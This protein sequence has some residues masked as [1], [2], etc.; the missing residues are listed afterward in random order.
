MMMS[1]SVWGIEADWQQSM[2]AL[3]AV[4]KRS[5]LDG[6]PWDATCS[7]R[8]YVIEWGKD[9]PARLLAL[10]RAGHRVVFTKEGNDSSPFVARHPLSL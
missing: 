9:K 10:Y 8:D 7:R 3:L 4:T 1:N 6:I 5:V 2:P